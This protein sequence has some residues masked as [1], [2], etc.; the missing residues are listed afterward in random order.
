M[1]ELRVATRLVLCE[2]ALYRNNLHA[3]AYAKG[4]MEVFQT[5]L[6]NVTLIAGPTASGK[7][8]LAIDI[9][10]RNNGV[11]I[12]TDSMQVYDVL[13]VL[14]ARPSADELRQAPHL[15]YGH[16]APSDQYSTG[17]WLK[18][19]SQILRDL[20]H[21]QH[22]VFVGGTGL[23]FRALMGGLSPMPEIDAVAREHWR[24]ELQEKGAEDL[25]R[26]LQSSDPEAAKTLN[27]S[28]GQRIARALE[29]LQTSGKSILHWQTQRGPQLI[30]PNEATKIV[31]GP[32]RADLRKRIDSRFDQMIELGAF[33]EVKSL[34]ALELPNSMPAMKA[35]GVQQLSAFLDG[36][37]ALEE[38]IERSKIATRQ[39]AKRQMTWFRNQLDENWRRM[40][41]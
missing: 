8:A 12:N 30:D 34:L 35:I 21:H 16:K 29:V 9:A 19:V 40:V 38:A 1:S 14:T 3:W 18:D 5:M 11:I 2:L 31:L 7:S 37:L 28:D 36:D 15:L 23:Y 33:E 17:H 6:T 25:H 24:A 10:Q 32:D 41:V 22:A 4:W 26:I 27:P 20:D 39:Y 13:S